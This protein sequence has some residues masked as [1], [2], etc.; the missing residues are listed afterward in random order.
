MTDH[1]KTPIQFV[2]P[3]WTQRLNKVKSI[4]FNRKLEEVCDIG[5]GSGKLLQD[6]C[7]VSQMT[8]LLGLDIDLISLSEAAENCKPMVSNYYIK[9]VKPLRFSLIAGSC[10][11]PTS[12][13]PRQ[14]QCVSC[15]EV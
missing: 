3:L 9:R 14:I 1:D 6:L 2:P 13:I 5:C 8:K 12:L 11:S 15:C 7:H 4:I 10:L